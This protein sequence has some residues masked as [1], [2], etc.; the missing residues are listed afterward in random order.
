MYLVRTQKVLEAT[1]LEAQLASWG[2]GAEELRSIKGAF[3]AVEKENSE[4]REQAYTLRQENRNA[5]LQVRERDQV[6]LIAFYNTYKKDL[7]SF[8]RGSCSAAQHALRSKKDQCICSMIDHRIFLQKLREANEQITLL[9]REAEVS[10]RATVDLQRQLEAAHRLDYS[11]VYESV[12]NLHTDR[13]ADASR[14]Q[15]SGGL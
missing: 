13:L 1:R 7:Y 5:D 9:R 3:T 4:L 10:E 2:T 11:S 12:D 6:S 8:G 14:S 15:V